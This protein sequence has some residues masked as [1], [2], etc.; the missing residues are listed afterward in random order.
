M[1]NTLLA[2]FL[3]SLLS[4]AFA[5]SKKHIDLPSLDKSR[6]SIKLY[7][8]KNYKDQ[9]RWPLV[10]SLHG[11]TGSKNFQDG[12]IKLRN[13]VSKAGFV[14]ALPNGL[15]NSEEKRYWNASNFCCD[16]EDT[17]VD[18]SKY[19]K[20]IIEQVSNSSRYGRIDPSRIYLVGY[21]NGAFMAN[22]LAC[23]IDSKIAGLITVSG[24]ADLRDENE[25]LITKGLAACKHNRAIKHLHIH[26]TNDK[27]IS[28]NGFDNGRTGLQGVD[29]YM[30]SWR[31]QNNCLKTEVVDKKINVS[32]LNFGKETIHT[33]WKGCD[34]KLELMK[35]KKAGHLIIFK[36]KAIKNMSKFLMGS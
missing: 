17:N 23:E 36:K 8:P 35:V 32:K 6:D 2:I 14:L 7:L 27:T 16:F 1:K 29:E 13:Y 24:T 3:M 33:K 34:A 25:K 19:I 20:S 28:Y 9:E 12:H 10:I 4:S 22:K 11:Y 30:E 5:L 26:G 21:S 18:D 31:K 15:E